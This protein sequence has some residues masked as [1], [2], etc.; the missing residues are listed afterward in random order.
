M[1]RIIFL[2]AFLV[3]SALCVPQRSLAA[4]ADAR[5]AQLLQTSG[6]AIGAPALA[7]IKIFTTE[8]KVSTAGLTGSGVSWEAPGTERFAETYST[9]PIAGGDGF[10]GTAFWNVDGSGLAW[11]DGSTVGRAQE[12]AQAYISNYSLWTPQHAGATVTWGGARA[13]KGVSYDVLVIAPRNAAVPFE[14]WFDPSTH[15]PV[16]ATQTIGPLT[17]TTTFTNYRR[18]AGVMFPFSWHQDSGDGNTTDVKI[19][20]IIVNPPGGAA[21]LAKP[22]SHVHDSSMLGGKTQTSIPFDLVENHVYLHVMLNGKGPY[23]FIFDTGGANIVDTEV[24]KEIGESA[25]GSAAGSGV[26]TETEAVSFANVKSLQVGDALLRDQLF[27]VAPVRQGFG[28]SAGQRVDGLIGFE[29]L[30]RFV[31]TFDYGNSVVILALPGVAAPAGAD[32]VPIVMNGKQPEFACAVDAIPSRCTLDTGARDSITLQAPVLSDHPAVVPPNA[33]APGVTGF[34][35]GGAAYGR[36]GRL[37]SL[38]FGKFTLHDVIGDYTVQA[39]GAFA[40]PFVAGNVGGGIWKRFA[41]TLDYDK[42]TMALVPDAAY[43]E[44]DSYERAGVFLISSGGKYVI[45][46]VRANTP[47]AGAGLVKGDTIDSIDG[48]PASSMSL[49]AVRAALMRPAG[50]L[51]KLGVAAKDGTNR[52]V[53][54]TLADFV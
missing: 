13:I 44:P 11:T 48:Q 4:V 37:Q 29:V 40:M 30:S 49:D 26:G 22:P 25:A 36:L 54:L 10:D 45:F 50:T 6:A 46:D 17:S 14:M 3:S 8:S 41:L 28:A 34:G 32:V 9:P 2:T 53:D 1:S 47:A 31:T 39:K 16:Q 12:I 42:L 23:R 18:V 35:F 51:V 27:A 52:E 33:S 15:L 19:T 20:S 38:A 43:S 24:A 5:V 7:R 21:H